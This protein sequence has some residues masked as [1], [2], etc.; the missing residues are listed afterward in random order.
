MALPSDIEK[1]IPLK[2]IPLAY[3]GEKTFPEPYLPTG[4]A[5][6]MEIGKDDYLVSQLSRPLSRIVFVF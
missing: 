5:P 3:G 6:P 4:C 2:E 1:H